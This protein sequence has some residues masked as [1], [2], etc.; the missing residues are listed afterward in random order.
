MGVVISRQLIL[1]G[2]SVLF[3][4]CAAVVYDLIRS[5][6]RFLPRLTPLFDVLYAVGLTFAAAAFLFRPARGELR[7]YMLT[8]AAG[9]AVIFFCAFSQPLRPLWDF[10]TGTAARIAGIF[11]LPLHRMKILLKKT[12]QNGKNLFYF[13]GKCLTIRGRYRSSIRAGNGKARNGHAQPRTERVQGR[14]KS[15]QSHTQV[16]AK[17]AQPHTQVK[18][19][20]SRKE[21]VQ[22]RAKSPKSRKEP[23]KSHVNTVK[24][25]GGRAETH[26]GQTVSRGGGNR[27]GKKQKKAQ[28]PRRMDGS[29][30]SDT[31][32]D[33]SG[34]AGVRSARTGRN[35]PSGT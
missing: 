14:A 24:G 9:G 8:G 4:V 1:F 35:R 30:D 23:V 13:A 31:V 12:F 16:R 26:S 18:S 15:A 7:G 11:M 5:V 22:G 28:V 19:A 20:Q 34:M 27:Y 3:G 21:R 29:C 6:R 2:Q 33:G 17:S 32:S 25:S 10:W